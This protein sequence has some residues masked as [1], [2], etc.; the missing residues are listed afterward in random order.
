MG[1]HYSG[2][3][4]PVNRRLRSTLGA[5]L[6]TGAEPE[7]NVIVEKQGFWSLQEVLRFVTADGGGLGVGEAAAVLQRL[8]GGRI[9]REAFREEIGLR[10]VGARLPG[11][12]W[13]IGNCA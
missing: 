8:E 13:P 1:R 7:R 9:G 12:S 11:R 2:N 5:N 4:A 10:P 3:G 6:R